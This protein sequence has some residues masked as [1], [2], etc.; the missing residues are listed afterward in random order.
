MTGRCGP[1]A[2]TISTACPPSVAAA[3]ATHRDGW[4]FRFSPAEGESG[5]FDGACVA[6]PSPLAPEHRLQAA[7]I[8]KEA[9]TMY[10]EARAGRH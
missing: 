9:G 7:R 5:V 10:M 1:W 4:V 8:A 6:Q 3:T 2:A